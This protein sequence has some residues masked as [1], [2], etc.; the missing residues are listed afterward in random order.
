MKTLFLLLLLPLASCVAYKDQAAYFG[1]VGL[2]A[3]RITLPGRL[4]IINANMSRSISAV[5]EAVRKMW[6]AYLME[7]GL[8]YIAGQYYTLQG[9][10]VA[11]SKAIELEKLKNAA[12]EAEAAAKLAELKAAYPNGLVP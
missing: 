7:Q 8:E 10:K 1:A 5:T 9:A 12:S 6:S 11:S 2:D 4:E 3:D